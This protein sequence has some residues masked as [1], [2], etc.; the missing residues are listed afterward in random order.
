METLKTLARF[1]HAV[2]RFYT[3]TKDIVATCVFG[4]PAFEQGA[5]DD[6]FVSMPIAPDM[7]TPG[8]KMAF[9]MIG[10]RDHR[11]PLGP[12]TVGLEDSDAV[13]KFDTLT[14][15]RGGIL[16]LGPMTIRN[17]QGQVHAIRTALD[18]ALKPKVAGAVS[19]TRKKKRLTEKGRSASLE[20]ASLGW[21]IRTT[22]AGGAHGLMT[23]DI[24]AHLQEPED[25][26]I[27]AMNEL[28]H[29]GYLENAPDAD[30]N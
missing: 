22:F 19:T 18:R 15:E 23:A 17:E 29:L 25:D 20:P 27:L 14:I 1:D 4:I 8:G 12:I 3:D 30:G 24:A 16:A 21:R 10:L 11:T 6:T 7:K 2:I 28:F 9:A 26:V 5:D 13:F